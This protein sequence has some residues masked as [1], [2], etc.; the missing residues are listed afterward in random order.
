MSKDFFDLFGSGFNSIKKFASECNAAN[1]ATAKARL[2]MLRQNATEAIRRNN[3]SLHEDFARVVKEYLV[4]NYNKCGLD[5]PK[6]VR[7][8]ICS[9]ERDNIKVN[10]PDTASYYNGYPSDFS[11]DFNFEVSREP[12]EGNI[13]D[14]NKPPRVSNEEIEILMN[15][16]LR[17]HAYPKGFTFDRVK[18]HSKPQQ[19]WKVKITVEHV[20]WTEEEIMRRMGGYII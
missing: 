15:E 14:L 5:E 6:T 18:V 16:D 13:H 4:S 9:N 3:A 17:K 7:D 10:I 12:F 1:D 11:L 20:H 8:V 19:Q 2:A